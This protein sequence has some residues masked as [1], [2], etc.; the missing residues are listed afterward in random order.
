M[1]RVAGRFRHIVTK[2][3]ATLLSAAILLLADNFSL[4]PA[5]AEETQI[6]LYKITIPMETGKDV[7]VTTSDG[8]IYH[9]GQVFALPQTTRWP[10]YTA[11]A[12]GPRRVCASAV[13]ALHMLVSIEKEKGRTL[14][15]I[16]S[17]TIAPAAGPG[18]SIV[19]SS[20]AGTGIFE[21]GLPCRIKNYSREKGDRS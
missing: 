11:S 17:E 15:I 10:S 8:T 20:E 18:A 1:V 5:V 12:W 2:T 3:A 16:P 21:R 6:P 7:T 19:I 13:N 14:S 9:V 4:S